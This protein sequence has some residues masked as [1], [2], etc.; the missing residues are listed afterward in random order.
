MLM[1]FVYFKLQTADFGSK[2]DYFVS[3]L[4]LMGL[5]YC[6]KYLDL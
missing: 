5:N 1:Q 3:L 6:Y 4:Y 2:I